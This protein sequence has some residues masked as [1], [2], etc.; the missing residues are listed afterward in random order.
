MALEHELVP[1]AAE[2][3]GIGGAISNG[4]ARLADAEQD[5]EPIAIEL[6]SIA[7]ALKAIAHALE[8]LPDAVVKASHAPRPVI[9]MVPSDMPPHRQQE[10]METLAGA[11]DDAINRRD[12]P[13][14]QE[15]AP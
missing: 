13:K 2:V 3:A 8:P 15:E 11:F 6:H 10:F 4:F 1:I 5:L 7:L 12:A 9:I 14:D